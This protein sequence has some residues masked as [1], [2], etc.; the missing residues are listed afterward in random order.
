MQQ[1]PFYSLNKDSYQPISH[2]RSFLHE[3]YEAINSFIE[4]NFDP[5]FH[6]LIAKPIKS[7]EHVNW[8]NEKLEGKI[9]K[10]DKFKGETGE[11]LKK[12]YNALVHQIIAK[13]E[14]FENSDDENN[15]AWAE[16][17]KE[18]F[19]INRNMVFSN[20]DSITIVWGYEFKEKGK[21]YMPLEAFAALLM[22]PEDEPEVEEFEPL[23]TDES[24]QEVLQDESIQE[25]SIEE[26]I[27]EDPQEIQSSVAAVKKEPTKT[28]SKIPK[29]VQSTHWFLLMLDSIERF[30][31]KYWYIL[32]IIFLLLLLWFLLRGCSGISVSDVDSGRTE[33]EKKVRLREI[34]PPINRERIIPID[35]SKIIEDENGG[36]V[37]SNILNMA[38][39]DETL[40][41]QDFAIDL[42]DLY[43]SDDYPITYM[44]TAT[45]RLVLQFPE[46]QKDSVKLK[47]KE[48]LDHYAP[49]IWEEELFESHKRFNDPDF[50][51]SNKKHHLVQTGAP[52]AWDIT[53][54][55]TSIVIAIIDNAFDLRHKEIKSN[56][57]GGR[58]TA[59]RIRDIFKSRSDKS[60]HGTHVAGIALGKA[61]NNFG[62]CGIAPDC[63]F[64]P[65]Q[66]SLDDN[67]FYGT[68]VIDGML[69]AINHG[70][71]VINMSLGLGFRDARG[72]LTIPPIN[73][74]IELNRWKNT[75]KT[76]QAE[77][78][79]I[80]LKK[81]NDK[82]IFVVIAAGN[83]AMP[84]GL[85]PKSRS[86][87]A[88]KVCAT[89]MDNKR[90]DFSNYCIQSNIGADYISAPGDK[91]WSSSRNNGFKSISGTSMASPL[92]AGAVGLIKSVNNSLTNE[93]IMSILKKTSL[94]LR[95]SKMPKFIQINEAVK[96]AVR[97]KQ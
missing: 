81:A 88:L 24:I 16:S 47:V 26:P 58:N 4:L 94:T 44:D 87:L 23:N 5:K 20:G 7:G 19:D 66:A 76:D 11:K 55:D 29:A 8:Y 50:G 40:S 10:L 59:R 13:C 65:I 71:D 61:D 62:L 77:F 82:N 56:I 42:K 72:N 70:A 3:Q 30:A 12:Q 51:N 97:L 43:P 85:D 49:L 45:S 2:G 74:E 52:V 15:K 96:E 89:N 38:I 68:D 67:S 75:F 90:A 41:F 79:N 34:L 46:G 31:K 21:Y 54:G 35:T 28:K 78:W 37:V 6:D 63:S 83:D 92:V 60:V 91:I 32:L 69:Y 14:Y 53:T 95:D 73:S 1:K 80:L 86:S 84:I 39:A 9:Q 48:E 18:V 57:R 33:K 22:E 64:M 27:S 25:E 36:R 17:I 93:Q